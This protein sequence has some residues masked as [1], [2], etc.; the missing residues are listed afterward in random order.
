MVLLLRAGTPRKFPVSTTTQQSTAYER[1]RR[2]TSAAR[3]G[4]SRLAPG[5]IE[6]EGSGSST[7]LPS[8]TRKPYR[9]TTPSI[10]GVPN[11]GF[12]RDARLYVASQGLPAVQAQGDDWSVRPDPIGGSSSWRSAQQPGGCRRVER[13]SPQE[14]VGQPR[15]SGQPEER[16]SLCRLKQYA[17]ASLHGHRSVGTTPRASARHSGSHRRACCP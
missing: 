3:A 2:V 13:P 16:G 15:N 4:G 1:V 6:P 9:R 12:S 11:S 5:W 14:P 10:P 17:R 7:R 8:P